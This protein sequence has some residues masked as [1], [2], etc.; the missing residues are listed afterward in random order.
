MLS[1]MGVKGVRYPP[2]TF[3]NGVLDEIS[4]S[5]FD[6]DSQNNLHRSRLGRGSLHSPK[7]SSSGRIGEIFSYQPFLHEC[8]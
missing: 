4:P 6:D 7:R 3:T 5:E 1:M 8:T 2:F